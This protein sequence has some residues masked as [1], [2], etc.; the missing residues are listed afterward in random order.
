MTLQNRAGWGS[1]WWDGLRF[2]LLK[3]GL[4]EK[5]AFEQGLE[6]WDLLYVFLS[7]VANLRSLCSLLRLL[8]SIFIVS[9]N[10]WF[11]TYFLFFFLFWQNL[12]FL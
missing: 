1:A 7:F 2:T 11:S 6:A 10:E 4:A 8:S 12:K 3:V 9:K 5:V